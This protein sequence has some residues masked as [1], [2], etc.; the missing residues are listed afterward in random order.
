MVSLFYSHHLVF[1]PASKGPAG[2]HFLNSFC[3]NFYCG[4]SEA[5]YIVQSYVEYHGRWPLIIYLFINIILVNVVYIQNTPFSPMPCDFVLKNVFTFNIRYI[6][7]RNRVIKVIR[8]MVSSKI[9][10]LHFALFYKIENV[11]NLI[12]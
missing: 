11:K 3:V 9:F 7:N 1:D 4:V 12:S 8:S 5:N 2:R 6:K 10:L